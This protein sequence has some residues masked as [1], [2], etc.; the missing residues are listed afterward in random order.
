MAQTKNK[1]AFDR[2]YYENLAKTVSFDG[3]A[4]RKLDAVQNEMNDSAYEYDE[5]DDTEA[6]EEYEEYVTVQDPESSEAVEQTSAEQQSVKED[7]IR[8]T[9]YV[10]KT[11]F[12]RLV[13]VT[14]VF[15]ALVSSAIYMLMLQSKVV[16]T[17]KQITSSEK[18]LSD[19]LALNSSLSAQLDTNVDR[20]Y[21]YN[22]AVGRLGMVYPDNNR[23]TTYEVA[24]SDHVRQYGQ[25][26]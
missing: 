12:F 8:K 25:F 18:I 2:D 1:Y 13:I 26:K 14:C 11:D 24:D 10:V 15:G 17:K 23:V 19:A 4:A 9:R 7:V 16:Q 6:Y 21:I 22:V 5:Y 3:N 20:N